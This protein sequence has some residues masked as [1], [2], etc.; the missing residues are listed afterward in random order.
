MLHAVAYKTTHQFQTHMSFK[1]KTSFLFSGLIATP[2]FILE[3]IHPSMCWTG[4]LYVLD[5]C[6]V[7]TGLVCCM[8]RT[9]VLYA[10]DWCVVCTGLVCCMYWT[11]VLYALDW[12][13]VCTG[14]AIPVQNTS[15]VHIPV[16]FNTPVQYT[17]I[18]RSHPLPTPWFATNLTN[19][20]LVYMLKLHGIPCNS[21]EGRLSPPYI[22][23]YSKTHP[24]L[25]TWR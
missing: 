13:V 2:F 17:G 21:A 12:C 25:Q 20:P 5:W 18:Y 19:H 7:C 10:L 3:E 22:F 15:P 14:L 11:G 8:Y 9:G 1:L 6:V 16:Q 4:V 24:L 23:I